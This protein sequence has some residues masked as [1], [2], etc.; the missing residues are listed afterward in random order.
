M[1][2]YKRFAA[3]LLA[4]LLCGCSGGQKYDND[5]IS[6][7]PVSD[8]ENYITVGY[9]GVDE[10]ALR[11]LAA[12]AVH[13]GS[14]VFCDLAAGGE[15][16]ENILTML[17][18]GAAPD[19]ILYESLPHEIIKEYFCP[20]DRNVYEPD[21]IPGLVEK[22]CLDEGLYFLPGP[23]LAG[24]VA[25][26]REVIDS[27]VGAFPADQEAMRGLMNRIEDYDRKNIYVPS[28]K[29]DA[30]YFMSMC[31]FAGSAAEDFGEGLYCSLLDK[32]TLF[33]F[34]MRPVFEKVR[35]LFKYGIIDI[36]RVAIDKATA[37]SRFISGETVMTDAYSDIFIHEGVSETDIALAPYP[38]GCVLVKPAW[39]AGVVKSEERA[40]EQEKQIETFLAYMS[41]PE[42]QSMLKKP[43][44]ALCVSGSG[45]IRAENLYDIGSAM[46]AGNIAVVPMESGRGRSK[47]MLSLVSDGFVSLYSG[48]KT[49]GDAAA[50]VDVDY[51]SVPYKREKPSSV[52]CN[53][54]KDFTVLET[55]SLIADVFRSLTGADIAL[56]PNGITEYGN[57]GRIYKGDV[58]ANDIKRISPVTEEDDK[59]LAVYEITGTSLREL[60]ADPI[61]SGKNRNIIYAVSGI[62]VTMAPWAEADGRLIESRVGSEGESILPGRLYKVAAW[63]GAIDRSYIYTTHDICTDLGSFAD[64]I[65]TV[66]AQKGRIAPDTGTRYIFRYADE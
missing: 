24:G 51:T 26:H 22:L 23:V 36:D 19:I 44:Q 43:G 2:I 16:E 13:D 21:Y 11:R 12:D 56:H 25:Y 65:G 58:T 45:H 61:I 46:D 52:I 5:I 1:R 32:E 15:A 64:I 40:P 29:D 49:A 10:N 17:E 50:A 8:T 57:A 54:E 66:F 39:Y 9:S 63:E 62:G 30:D 59:Y 53:A 41:S 31:G 35:E 6:M 28:Y 4:L 37:L 18:H 55:S 42:G 3:A 14:F 48:D 34:A 20:L 47:A 27:S 60:L 33:R 7:Q 38:G